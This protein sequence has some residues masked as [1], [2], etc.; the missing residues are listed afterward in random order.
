[1]FTFFYCNTFLL[2]YFFTC[3]APQP[4]SPYASLSSS[5]SLWPWRVQH[6]WL[7][8]R[9]LRS[10]WR[11]MTRA[12]LWVHLPRAEQRIWQ[13]E[14]DGEEKGEE[15]EEEVEEE[16]EGE[17]AWI[18]LFYVSVDKNGHVFL[19]QEA[20]TK[21]RRKTISSTC[22]SIQGLVFLSRFVF[23]KTATAGLSWTSGTWCHCGSSIQTPIWA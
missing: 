22:C 23:V 13:E 5:P 6:F 10:L 20:A 4:G 3:L 15:D 9:T 18:N 17:H 12:R 7:E 14:E 21:V 1:M 8:E 11:Q 16:K 19:T 2:L